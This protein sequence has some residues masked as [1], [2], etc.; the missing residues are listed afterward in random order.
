MIVD[1]GGTPGPFDIGARVVTPAAWALGVRRLDWLVLTHG[2]NDH[3]GGAPSVVA[4]LTPR[5]IWEGVPVPRNEPLRR[6]HDNA[7]ARGTVWRFVRAGQALELGG[8]TVLARHPAAPEWER[9]KVRNDDSVVLELRYGDVAMLLTGDAGAEFERTI[10]A[11]SDLPPLR[12]LKV[13]H[14]GSRTS[15]SDPFVETY[16]PQIAL[17]SVG[18]G[19]L[20]GHPSPDVLS[21]LARAGAR[22]FRTDQDGAITVETDGRVV[23]VLTMSGRSWILSALRTLS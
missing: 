1:T 4:D 7:R 6:L 10:T 9:Q 17:V 8:V 13:G 20:F 22:I 11:E 14:H 15:T 16:Q 21:R 19:N 2:D 12:V 18:R 3:A 23:R 5:E